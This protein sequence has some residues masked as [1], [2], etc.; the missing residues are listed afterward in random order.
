MY[1]CGNMLTVVSRRLRPQY[2]NNKGWNYDP[3]LQI[4]RI[5]GKLKFLT[6]ADGKVWT[7][8]NLADTRMIQSF[9]KGALNVGIYQTTYSDNQAAVSFSDIHIWQ[10]K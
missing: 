6:S 9:C 3:Y 8:M 7:E 10:K 2:P 4:Q 5:N 1:N